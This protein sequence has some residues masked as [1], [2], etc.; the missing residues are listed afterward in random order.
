MKKSLD[1]CRS[2][3]C[4]GTSFYQKKRE[5]YLFQNDIILLHLCH[6]P[7]DLRIWNLFL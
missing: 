7:Y 1:I 3:R 6:I 5:E 2:G 4:L